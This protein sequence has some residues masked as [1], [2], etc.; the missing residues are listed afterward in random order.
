ML[1]QLALVPLACTAM[2]MEPAGT[3]PL[4]VQVGGTY[5]NPDLREELETDWGYSAGIAT[6]LAESGLMGVPSLDIDCRYAPD[7]EGSLTTFEATYAERA[8]IGDRH[9]IG[10]GIG[11]NFVRLKLDETPD[12]K[13]DSE[14]RWDV[15]GKAMIGYL[16]SDRLFIEG[17]YH[18]TRE[19]LDMDT[20]S[21]TLAIGYWF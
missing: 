10:V 19:A 14:R 17:T 20:S 3:T 8:L 6:L 11:S 15:G 12:R 2:A 7:G 13:A 5:M 1:R 16:V 21:A 18:Y 4:L 9:W